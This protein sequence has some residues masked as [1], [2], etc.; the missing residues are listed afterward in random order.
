MHNEEHL[1][2]QSGHARELTVGQCLYAIPWHICPTVALH[3]EVGVVDQG[4][5]KG[6]WA[7]VARARKLTV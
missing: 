1:V 5:V 7:V 6:T 4:H 2:L 3:A